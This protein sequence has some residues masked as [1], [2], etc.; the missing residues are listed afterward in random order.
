MMYPLKRRYYTNINQPAR[1]VFY[2][3][4][5]DRVLTELKRGV[6]GMNEKTRVIQW[7]LKEA[8]EVAA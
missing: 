4:I 7:E 6:I 3:Y 5:P 8:K 1:K 2:Q